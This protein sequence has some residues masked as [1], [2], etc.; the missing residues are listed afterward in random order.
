[1]AVA[2]TWNQ[3]R[4]MTA[5]ANHKN[6][7]VFEE[8]RRT[9]FPASS[10]SPDKPENYTIKSMNVLDKFVIFHSRHRLQF[11]FSHSATVEWL[12]QFP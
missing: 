4:K 1:M 12:Y 8:R 10:G 6:S 5:E 7:G 9:F 11:A 3:R 2:A